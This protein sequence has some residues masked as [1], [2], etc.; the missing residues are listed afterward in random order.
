MKASNTC[1]LF[2]HL[3]LYFSNLLVLK[4]VAKISF[5]INK[6]YVDKNERLKVIFYKINKNSIKA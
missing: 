3:S 4:F 6:K 1:L 2:D 5:E